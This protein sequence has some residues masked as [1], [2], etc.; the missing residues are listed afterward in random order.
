MCTH[1]HIDH[2]GWNTKLQNGRWV[3]TFPNANYLFHSKEY[4]YWEQEHKNKE[5]ARGPFIDSVLPVVEAGR[6]TMVAGDH[7]IDAGLWL[8]HTP[9]HTP[10]AVCLHVEDSGEHGIF[11]GDLMHHPLQVPEPQWS[12]IFC[13][14]PHQ[15][16]ETRMAFVDKHAETETMVLPAHFGGVGGGHIVGGGPDGKPKF[17]FGG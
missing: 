7:E 11:C 3:P 8:E 17:R 9:G 4:E 1:L 10:G 15:S 12:S 16:R 2:V 6:A 5:W 14:D 13:E